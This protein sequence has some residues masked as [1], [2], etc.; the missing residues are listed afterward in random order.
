MYVLYFVK[1]FVVHFLVLSIVKLQKFCLWFSEHTQI[2]KCW[3]K[4][5]QMF[6]TLLLILMS[7]VKVI[8]N[9]KW[10]EVWFKKQKCGLLS[11]LFDRF[12]CFW[13]STLVFWWLLMS[14]DQSSSLYSGVSSLT[15]VCHSKLTAWLLL[16]MKM[17]LVSLGLH[18]KVTEVNLWLFAQFLPIFSKYCF[19]LYFTGLLL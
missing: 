1:I 13:I 5:I 18:F 2:N 4:L 14:R 19:H 9:L 11:E 3:Q 6:T 10:S 15:V 8:W 17:K 12:K 7:D 16:K